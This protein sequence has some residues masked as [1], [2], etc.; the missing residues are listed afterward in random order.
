MPKFS[1]EQRA[2][3]F[4]SL[5]YRRGSR[6]IMRKFTV[7]DLPNSQISIC[8]T[9]RGEEEIISSHSL[10]D[11]VSATHYTTD[12]ELTRELINFIHNVPFE[13]VALYINTFPDFAKW[14]LSIGE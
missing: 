4:S 14:R 3:L 10:V 2:E 9:I 8:T 6:D 12:N 5:S 11:I 1:S 13:E 7:G